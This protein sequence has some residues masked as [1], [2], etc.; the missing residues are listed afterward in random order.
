M[1]KQPPWA[2]RLTLLGGAALGAF[3]LLSGRLW[4]VAVHRHEEQ[5]TRALIRQRRVVVQPACRRQVLDRAGRPLALDL[6]EEDVVVDLP[7]L[8]PSLSLVAPLA[9]ALGLTRPAAL[10]RLREARATAAALGEDEEGA[11]VLV[12]GAPLERLER[13]KKALRGAHGLKATIEPHGLA[14]HADAALL[15]RAGRTIERLAPLLGVEPAD[16]AGQ[17]EQGVQAIVLLDDKDERVARWRRPLVLVEAA[18]FEVVARVGELG[19]DL[20]GVRVLRRWRRVHPRGPVASH[21]VGTLGLPTAEEAARDVAAGRVLDHDGEALGLLLGEATTLP[22]DVRLAAEPYGRTGIERTHDDA[23]RGRPGATLLV[24]D[25]KGRTRATLLEVPAKD[26][27]DVRLTVDVGLQAAVEAA[28]DEAV[29]RHGDPTSGGA[30]VLL[31]LRDGGV[32]A[33]ASAPRFDP[34]ALGRDF[35][36]LVADPRR[37]L[38]DRSVRAFPP[39]S[40]WKIL[41]SFALERPEGPGTAPA[42]LP[43]GWTTECHGAL[44]PGRPGFRCDGYHGP[45]DLARAIERSCNVFFFRAADRLGIDALAT[46]SIAL[47]MGAPVG[48][49]PG[50]QGG[51]VPSTAMKGERL[52]RAARQVGRAGERVGQ[53]AATWP[54]D[55]AQLHRSLRRLA[56]A[57]WWLNACGQDR[58]PLPGDARNAFI[59][60][61]DVLATPVQVAWLAALIAGG[62]RAAR[63]HV[64]ADRPVEWTDVPLDPR[65]LAT[66]KQGMRRVVTHGT[67]SDRKLGLR[68][69]DLAGKT[70]TAERRKGEPKLA[71]FMGYYPASRPE[72]ALAILVERTHG[73]GGEVC[74]PVARVAVR[75]WE[76]HL[77]GKT[78]PAPRGGK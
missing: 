41:T 62:G 28:L 71:W 61:G 44:F 38:L 1:S 76:E 52:E 33:I 48:D 6:P 8:D 25:A 36:A 26:G 14:L 12:G 50:E 22:A 29:A 19:W 2:A 37:P 77:K 56:R 60:Q 54:F 40:T 32:L 55:E 15:A 78:P 45:T 39:A 3:L 73:H 67:A 75:A 31:D 23:L 10:D 47:G 9:S 59:G 57:T 5:R 16:L 21:L 65:T 42:G 24:R 68:D 70:G 4:A 34:D 11:T 66:V 27:R 35:E 46:W 13:V 49:L 17:I 18:P 63:P 51:L 30:A 69:L 43:S 72:L 58:I 20:P 74:G 7:D 64:D 53:S